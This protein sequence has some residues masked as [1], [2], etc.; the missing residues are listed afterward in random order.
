[1][2]IFIFAIICCCLFYMARRVKFY[3][4]EL[5]FYKN[6]IDNDYIPKVKILEQERY[7]TKYAVRDLIDHFCCDVKD[8]N[9]CKANN[10]EVADS[11]LYVS[12]L[13]IT[14]QE[15]NSLYLLMMASLQMGCGIFSE[16]ST[17]KHLPV[18]AFISII[19]N[20]HNGH[21]YQYA[22]DSAYEYKEKHG[23]ISNA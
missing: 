7:L 17:E 3:R 15:A 13:N 8:Y 5:K 18:Y 11:V 19:E 10:K 22:I 20:L 4:S 16:I 14:V 2:I 1:M 9:E 12:K 6:I 23:E 21:A